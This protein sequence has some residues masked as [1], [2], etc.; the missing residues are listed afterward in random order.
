MEH[1]SRGVASLWAFIG[2]DRRKT[3]IFPQLIKLI[4]LIARYCGSNA[5]ICWKLWPLLCWNA[6]PHTCKN[7]FTAII[8]LCSSYVRFY[9]SCAIICAVKF[10][11]ASHPSANSN[12][13]VQFMLCLHGMVLHL[14]VFGWHVECCWLLVLTTWFI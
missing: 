12:Y 5:K 3:A 11:S 10:A 2:A 13:C 8:L 4:M 14:P 9:Y 6:G 7:M 1:T